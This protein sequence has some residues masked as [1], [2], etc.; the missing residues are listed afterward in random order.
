[1]DVTAAVFKFIF[2]MC[3]CPNI[4]EIQYK[5]QYSD[6]DFCVSQGISSCGI[7]EHAT[8]TNGAGMRQSPQ[9]ALGRKLLLTLHM[10]RYVR[11]IV[12]PHP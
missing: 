6:T 10:L 1:M 4:I 12:I 5:F 8:V 9:N 11:G 2:K 7:E 3:L